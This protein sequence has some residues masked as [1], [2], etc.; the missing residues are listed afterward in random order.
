MSA[1]VSRDATAADLMDDVRAPVSHQRWRHPEE[2]RQQ[3]PEEPRRRHPE[4]S[5][6]A[7][8]WEPSVRLIESL[9]D[10][11]RAVRRGGPLATLQAKVAVLRHRF[12]SAVT[13][14]DIPLNTWSLG[15]GLELPH[16]NGVV[17][18]PG[19]EI[20][21]N[22]RIFQQVTLGT[23]PIAGL[24]RIGSDVH[25]GA[26]AKIIGGVSVGD[27]AVIGANSVVLSDVPA[28]MTAAGIP[29]E[30]KPDARCLWD[31]HKRAQR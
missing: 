11:Q 7:R 29:A 20:G 2:P 27:R 1:A 18:H 24:P 16:P 22:C 21:K 9:R 4:E 23:G 3:H 26:G 12:W 13:G 10:Y 31:G 19:S 15:E 8:Y 30:L 25:I 28:D 5:R 17:I 14:A 6:V